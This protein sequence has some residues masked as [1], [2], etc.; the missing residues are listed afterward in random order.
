MIPIIK[1]LEIIHVVEEDFKCFTQ[2]MYVVKKD[3]NEKIIRKL[4]K[5]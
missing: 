3:E 4:M 1:I 5:E 2:Y